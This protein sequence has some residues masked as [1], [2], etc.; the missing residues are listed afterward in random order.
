MHEFASVESTDSSEPTKKASELLSDEDFFDKE[1]DSDTD[2]DKI[3]KKQAPQK[4]PKKTTPTKTAKKAKR[5]A[6]STS[7][8]SANSSGTGSSSDGSDTM[9]HGQKRKQINKR[10]WVNNS[11]RV[12]KRRRF[13]Y[14][15]RASP[16]R[17][18]R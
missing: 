10:Y 18:E 15:E 2:K 1:E 3:A 16:D 5:V 7:S 6:E 12:N 13:A 11:K 8:S 17:R 14:A 4:K 9:E